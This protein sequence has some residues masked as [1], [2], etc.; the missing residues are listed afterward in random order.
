MGALE[1]KRGHG[2]LV[3]GF[4]HSLKW[5]EI[6]VSLPPNYLEPVLFL[7]FDLLKHNKKFSLKGEHKYLYILDALAYKKIP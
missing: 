2:E 5:N 6:S 4:L 7:G 3:E 1:R